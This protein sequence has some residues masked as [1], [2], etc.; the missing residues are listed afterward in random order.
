MRLGLNYERI[1]QAGGELI[2]ISVDDEVRQAGMRQRWGFSHTRFVSDPG[3]TTYLEPLGLFDPNERGGIALPGMVVITPGGD[4]AYRFEGRDYADRTNDPVLYETLE[5]LEM[6]P[7]SPDVW[8]PDIVVPA[9][10]RGYFMPRN[11]DPYFR[12]NYFGATA[13]YRRAKAA[14]D[15][16]GTRLANEHRFMSKDTFEAWESWKHNVDPAHL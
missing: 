1:H 11:L 2:A 9:D 15:E 16:V 5:T 10:L 4:V 6:P 14:D 12:G 7:V 8:D 13:I 3:G